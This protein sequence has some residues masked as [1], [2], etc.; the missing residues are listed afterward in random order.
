MYRISHG[1]FCSAYLIV[2]WSAKSLH[3]AKKWLEVQVGQAALDIKLS[4]LFD[5]ALDVMKGTRNYRDFVF[6]LMK[7]IPAEYKWVDVAM[8]NVLVANF[9]KKSVYANELSAIRAG[10]PVGVDNPHRHHWEN[11]HLCAASAYGNLE[12]TASILPDTEEPVALSRRRIDLNAMHIDLNLTDMLAG[13]SG[14][15]AERDSR[16]TAMRETCIA[17]TNLGLT[18]QQVIN[19]YTEEG[20]SAVEELFIERNHEDYMD[21]NLDPVLAD[22]TITWI[23]SFVDNNVSTW[24]SSPSV[25]ALESISRILDSVEVHEADLEVGD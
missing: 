5:L 25:M 20:E 22:N 24:E 9:P 18:V 16:I 11:I 4:N 15:G 21:E 13:I 12:V 2:I 8:A 19:L 17:I 6:T 1:M 3:R 14:F 7:K 23:E 10:I